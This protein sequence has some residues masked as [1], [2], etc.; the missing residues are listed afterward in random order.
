MCETVSG[1]VRTFRKPRKGFKVINPNGHS[2]AHVI[3]FNWTKFEGVEHKAEPK[4]S[5]LNF[6]LNTEKV[7]RGGFHLFETLE[8]AKHY[9]IQGLKERIIEV[10][11]RGKAIPFTR[12]NYKGYAVE[13]VKVIR[14]ITNV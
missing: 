13:F 2:L 8:G 14:E 9:R 11:F 1:R 5:K 12:K 6:T 3:N 4:Y 7:T 10:E